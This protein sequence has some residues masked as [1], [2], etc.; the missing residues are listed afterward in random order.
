MIVDDKG[1][2][3]TQDH[4]RGTRSACIYIHIEAGDIAGLDYIIAESAVFFGKE[5]VG[6]PFTVACFGVLPYIPLSIQNKLT[7]FV[8]ICA[9]IAHLI[10]LRQQ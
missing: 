2:Q 5:A 3:L 7:V 1:V 8:Y 9:H 10:S 6:V 4:D